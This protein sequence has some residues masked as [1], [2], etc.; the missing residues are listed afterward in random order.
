MFR[1]LINRFVNTVLTKD[2]LNQIQREAEINAQREVEMDVQREIHRIYLIKAAEFKKQFVAQDQDAATRNLPTFDDINPHP[3]NLDEQDA[4]KNF[5][6]K[7]HDEAYALFVDAFETYQEDLMFMGVAAFLY[8]LPDGIAAAESTEY[9]DDDLVCQ[10]MFSII[11]LRVEYE[12]TEVRSAIPT[13]CGYLNRLL[14]R[15]SDDKCELELSRELR[16]EIE[17]FVTTH[18]NAVFG[19]AES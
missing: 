3:G 9:H 19:Q 8:Y 4:V 1:W 7:N 17:H 13:M 2:E 12:L 10:E 5:L 16:S 6:G 14:R 18:E 15:D 11:Q